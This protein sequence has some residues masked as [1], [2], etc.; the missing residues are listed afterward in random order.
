MHALADDTTGW[1][2]IASG[3]ACW[4]RRPASWSGALMTAAG[5][6]WFAGDVTTYALYLH[7]GPL[8][9]LVLTYPTGRVSRR[10]EQGAI[11]LAAAVAVVAPVARSAPATVT[12][13]AF[14][15]AVA[16]VGYLRARGRAR[17]ALLAAAYA[18]TFL[19]ALIA[20]IAIVRAAVTTEDAQNATLLLYEAG[21]C[22]LAIGLLVGLVYEPRER[23]AVGELLAELAETRSAPL[24]DA[25]ARALG[26]ASLEVGYWLPELQAYVDPV[27]R[28]LELPAPGG[29]R[30]ITPIERNGHAVAVLVHDPMVLND[31]GLEDAVASVARLAAANA[32]LQAEVQGRLTELEASRLRLLRSEDAERR[33]LEERLRDGAERRLL[34]LRQTLDS[35][36]DQVAGDTA[37]GLRI[38]QADTQLAETLADLR[39][40]ARGLHP[41]AL[42]EDG[43]AGALASLAERSPL[44]VELS[45]STD[46]L[47]EELEV[48]AYFVCSEALANV[49]KHA[50]ASHTSVRVTAGAGRVDIAVVDDGVGGADPTGGSGLRGLR[51]RVESLGGRLRVE[52]PSGHGTSVTAELP[53][54][55][56]RAEPAPRT[57]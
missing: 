3:L 52:S 37:T 9:A 24:R 53:L 44:A 54:A 39:E 45:L 1:V 26:D 27:G 29:P 23:A 40:L 25:L 36:R 31:P 16:G 56:R 41:R 21:L 46:R 57:A 32:R 22:V 14:V 19:G 10:L 50:S 4:W 8:V 7:R 49:A 42:I 17:R 28:S 6:A 43:L 15:I 34:G 5:L 33:R 18:T 51:D 12:L 48:A 30:A 2:L 13:A 35:A 38:G 11:A 55:H 20:G 47:P